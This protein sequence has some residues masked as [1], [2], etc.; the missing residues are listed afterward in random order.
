MIVAQ[1]LPSIRRA[2]AESVVAL[3][4]KGLAEA[5]VETHLVVIG[6]RRVDYADELIKHKVKVHFL[7]LHN[8]QAKF[9]RLDIQ[10]RIRNGLL[11]FLGELRPD[12]LHCHLPHGLIW[13]SGAAS[14]LG[15]KTFYTIHG[16]DPAMS[17][18][19]L[20]AWWHRGEFRR[21]VKV[22]NCRVLAVSK[23]AARHM[24]SGLGWAPHSIEVQSNPLDLQKWQSGVDSKSP[25]SLTVIM[26]GTLYQLK[27]VNIGI[28]ALKILGASWPGVRLVIVG[29]GPE[30]RKM[31][32]LVGSLG[33][34]DLVSF[35]G[36]RQDIPELL[37]T[38]G[39]MWLLSER[40]GM[41]MVLLEAM[42]SGL[43]VIATDVPGINELI[44]PGGNG[45]LVPLDDPLA[46]AETTRRLWGDP[47][48]AEALKTGGT[49][50][51]KQFELSAIVSQHL[52]RYTN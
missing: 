23:S 22:S 21:A 47:Q 25:E 2:G 15:L 26:V 27:R 31:E 41:P 42:A 43:P 38:A 30:R 35:L 12:I 45:L 48:L 19:G 11:S 4:C 49:T 13:A 9:Y 18:P 6:G 46:V 16:I 28:E 14:R 10:R 50:F 24:E 20:R 51:V 1:L 39:V 36:V 33:L 7:G 32:E 8:D 29:D 52:K 3:L 40:E 44:A 17:E 37:R 34:S 5:G